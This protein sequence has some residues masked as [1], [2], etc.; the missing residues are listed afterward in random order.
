MSAPTV[1][2]PPTPG[3]GHETRDIQITPIG[4][5]GVALVALI[6]FSMVA[7][8]ILMKYY[9]VREAA[10]SPPANPLA[11]QF[12]RTTPP[13]PQ[14][15]THPAADIAAFRAQEDAVLNGYGWVNKTAGVV[16]IPIA[17]AMEL[18]LQ[19]QG[20]GAAPAQ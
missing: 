13:A 16:R 17:R 19:R 1:Q 5:A 10:D 2:D 4:V 12:A 11:A 18:Q 15:Q 3:V 9:E 20:Q 14:L 6:V 8:L 7:M